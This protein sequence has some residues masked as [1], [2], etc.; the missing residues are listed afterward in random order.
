MKQKELKRLTRAELL[1][2]LLAQTQESER[3]RERLE[4][5]QA[6]LADRELKLSQAGDLAQAAV[7]VNGVMEAAQ[8]A[9]K[10]YLDNIDRMQREIAQTKENTERMEREA[11]ERC[12]KLL[13]E[14]R[15]QADRIKRAAGNRRKK[16]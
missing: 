7:A 16:R 1:E 9:A 11:Q 2:L 13:A 6:Q 15:K 3:L 8:A 14:A 5:A 4:T 12:E 10:Q